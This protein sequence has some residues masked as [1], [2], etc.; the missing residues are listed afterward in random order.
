M[1]KQN[2]NKLV[3]GKTAI[4]ELNDTESTRVAGGAGTTYVCSNCIPDPITDKLK[5]LFP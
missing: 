2:N 1:K 5:K 4:T 3:F